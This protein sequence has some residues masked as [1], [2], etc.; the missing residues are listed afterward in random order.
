M[1]NANKN[2]TLKIKGLLRNAEIILKIYVEMKIVNF[3]KKQNIN[4]KSSKQTGI[5]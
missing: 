1:R 2:T 4:K 5:L 3:I